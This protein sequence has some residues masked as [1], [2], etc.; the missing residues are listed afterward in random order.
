MGTVRFPFFLR[1]MPIENLRIAGEFFCNFDPVSYV[2]VID[3]EVS[4]AGKEIR[5]NYTALWLLAVATGLA[6]NLILRSFGLNATQRIV[7]IMGFLPLMIFLVLM[8]VFRQ[9]RLRR[10]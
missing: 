9:L 4:M 2:K 3:R 1:G 6:E 10:E 5:L 8:S 7:A